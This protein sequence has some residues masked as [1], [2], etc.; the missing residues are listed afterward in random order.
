VGREEEP[1]RALFSKAQQ[2]TLLGKRVGR[3]FAAKGKAGVK[4]GKRGSLKPGKVRIEL[5]REFSLQPFRE[6]TT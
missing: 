6:R 2:F 1:K 4:V 5:N 3:D